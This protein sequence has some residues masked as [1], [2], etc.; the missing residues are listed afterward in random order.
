MLGL[1]RSPTTSQIAFPNAF[2]PSNHVFHSGRV[3][4]G[5]RPPVVERGPVDEPDRA[6]LHGERA[7]LGRGHHRDRPGARERH[8]LNRQ[9]PEAPEAPQTST[10]SP[11]FTVFGGQPW[12]IRYAVA[13]VSVGA[14]ASSH[15]SGSALGRH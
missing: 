11:C 9:R 3:P 2:A 5:R 6:L 7:P 15:V 14:A 4:C 1:V 13:P 8:E 10:T 12:S